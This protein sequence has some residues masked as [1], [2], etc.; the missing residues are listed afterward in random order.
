KFN[1][2]KE[3]V[4]GLEA[5][6]GNDLNAIK[7]ITFKLNSF[8][9]LA[10]SKKPGTTPEVKP[11]GET[12]IENI[13]NKHKEI[14]DDELNNTKSLLDQFKKSIEERTNQAALNEAKKQLNSA[15]KH[16][17]KINTGSFDFNQKFNFNKEFVR[18]LEAIKGNDLN[19]IKEITFKLN[20]FTYKFSNITKTKN[21]NKN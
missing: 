19:A 1:F 20:S 11:E 17:A 18:G 21:G 13:I 2:N 14:K 16:A 10:T 9:N 12:T 4:R 8:I 3:F 5:I 15:L 7:E 6:K